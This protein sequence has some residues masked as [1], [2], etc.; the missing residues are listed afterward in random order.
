MKPGQNFL[1]GKKEGLTRRGM[2]PAN[3]C[4]QYKHNFLEIK[5]WPYL[6]PRVVIGMA[7]A[8]NPVL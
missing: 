1:R 4:R 3:M 6:H 8:Q 2:S 7:L 5:T